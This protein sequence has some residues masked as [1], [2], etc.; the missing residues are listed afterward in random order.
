MIVSLL[1]DSTEHPYYTRDLAVEPP[2]G[3]RFTFFEEEKIKICISLPSEMSELYEKLDLREKTKIEVKRNDLVDIL[4]KF[5]K[6]VSKDALKEFLN[7]RRL[8]I[9]STPE[10]C[11]GAAR[12]KG[13]RIR[14]ADIVRMYRLGYTKEE[15]AKW[16]S[17]N[18]EDIEEALKY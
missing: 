9:V 15:I 6:K 1:K 4:K 14:V 7:E 3:T 2:R 5:S 16:Y 13:R 8:R 18:L 17:L 11:S 10:V 12:I